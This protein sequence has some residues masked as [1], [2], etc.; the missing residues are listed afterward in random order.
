MTNDDV[1]TALSCFSNDSKTTLIWR[2]VEAS[3][4]VSCDA[5]VVGVVNVEIDK[6]LNPRFAGA[7][8]DMTRPGADLKN[9]CH[10]QG[11]LL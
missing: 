11:P 2:Y 3:K 9:N 1:K 4:D 5:F 8:F 10:D 6:N 7:V